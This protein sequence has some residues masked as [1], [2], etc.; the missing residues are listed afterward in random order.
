MCE[1]G[2]LKGWRETGG[3]DKP[4]LGRVLRFQ[5]CCSH[6]H[7]SAWRGSAVFYQNITSP[8]PRSSPAAH[9]TQ[10]LSHNISSAALQKFTERGISASV[11]PRRCLTVPGLCPAACAWAESRVWALSTTDPLDF[12]LCGAVLSAAGMLPGTVGDI[13]MAPVSPQPGNDCQQLRLF[14]PA[15]GWYRDSD[16]PMTL[17]WSQKCRYFLF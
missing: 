9:G 16:V 13:D 7:L 4:S 17:K 12:E 8:K 1:R 15:P 11:K 10:G 3:D 14:R 6:A 2:R 5:R